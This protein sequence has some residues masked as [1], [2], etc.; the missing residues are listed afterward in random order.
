[1]TTHLRLL[2][3]VFGYAHIENKKF[4]VLLASFYYWEN[5]PGANSLTDF[6]N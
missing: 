5:L 1:M 4:K 6:A 2:N 3:G